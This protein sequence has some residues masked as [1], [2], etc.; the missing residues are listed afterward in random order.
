[1][2]KHTHTHRKS[3]QLLSN[4]SSDVISLNTDFFYVC[5]HSLRRNDLKRARKV[6]D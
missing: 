5:F 1:M 6:A 2:A 4:D 3:Q